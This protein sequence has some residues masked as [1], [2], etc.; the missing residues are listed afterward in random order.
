MQGEAK[1]TVRG[2]IYGQCLVNVRNNTGPYVLICLYTYFSLI[3]PYA[4]VGGF[5]KKWE[6]SARKM[7]M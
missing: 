4:F 5:C 7:A 2:K 3:Q 1:I 6:V